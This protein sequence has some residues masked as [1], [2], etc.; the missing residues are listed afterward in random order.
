MF[1]RVGAG[2]GLLLATLVVWPA[3]PHGPA[4]LA[5]DTEYRVVYASA[6]RIE[7]QLDQLGRDGY[8]CVALA[9][10]E[11]SARVPGVVAI[12]G[13]HPQNAGPATHRALLVGRDSIKASL[14]QAGFEGFRL[15]GIVLDEAPPVPRNVA[16]MSRTTT[17]KWQYDAEVLLRYKDSLVRLNAIGRDGF[18]PVAATP[19]DN[20][21]V[22]EQRNW[23]VV[24]ERPAGGAPARE[25]AVR[26]DVGPTGLGRNLNDSGKQGYRVDLVWK[27]GNDYVAMMSRPA[28]ASPAAQ[29]FNVEGDAP[30]RMHFLKGLALGD[31]PY[32]DK[33]L[34]VADASVR[35]SNEFVDEVLPPL[36]VTGTVEPRALQAMATIGDHISRNHGYTVSYARV[37]RDP[38]GKIVLSVAMA[39]KD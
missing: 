15:C 4:V 22:P 28:G 25:I 5:A 27:E 11:P 32:L 2:F 8:A 30:S 37:S 18:V 12:V 21:R 3:R 7:Q 35:A 23:M 39:K 1:S 13:R 17:D 31:F 34:F 29:S 26:S 36:T 20:N 38:G 24:A 19:I 10:A 16:V 9:R 33:R 6:A 14:M